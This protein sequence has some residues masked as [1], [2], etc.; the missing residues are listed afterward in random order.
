MNTIELIKYL[1][2]TTLT[3][4]L[5]DNWTEEEINI[6]EN[7]KSKKFKITFDDDISKSKSN[8]ACTEKQEFQIGDFVF[9]LDEDF[10]GFESIVADIILDKDGCI[11]YTTKDGLDF[12]KENINKTV[13]K[14]EKDRFNF[15]SNNV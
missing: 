12:Y 1:A 10:K 6:L 7:L 2:K 9:F 13:F 11:C 5:T 4:D 3:T 14:T 15:V 8:N